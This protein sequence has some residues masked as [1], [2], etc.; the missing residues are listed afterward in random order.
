MPGGKHTHNR[1]ARGADPTKPDAD[2]LRRA[3]LAGHAAVHTRAAELEDLLDPAIALIALRE[4]RRVLGWARI[5]A[6][7]WGP[8]V[9]QESLRVL[10][11]MAHRMGVQVEP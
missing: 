1:P 5:T 11:A 3:F 8:L 6:K 9:L 2:D 7:P 4:V 10:R